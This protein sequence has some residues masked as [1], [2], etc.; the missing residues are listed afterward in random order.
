IEGKVRFELLVESPE[1]VIPFDEDTA[2]STE[3]CAPHPYDQL[4]WLYVMA[5]M[6]YVS[7]DIARYENGAAMFNMAYQNYGK[8]LKRRG[9]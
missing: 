6:D 8:W 9:A 7:G 5:M 2:E 1:D 3:L 4:Y